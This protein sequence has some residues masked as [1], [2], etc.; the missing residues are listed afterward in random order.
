MSDNEEAGN[1]VE[2]NEFEAAY[3][4]EQILKN[5]PPTRDFCFLCHVWE[6]M[7]TA[8]KTKPVQQVKRYVAQLKER[9]HTLSPVQFIEK[10][11]EYYQLRIR[12]QLVDDIYFGPGKKR[13][14]V[15]QPEWSLKTVHEHFYDHEK[16]EWYLSNVSI[17]Q[18]DAMLRRAANTVIPAQRGAL[19]VNGVKTYIDLHNLRAKIIASRH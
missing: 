16:E 5:P 1:N 18:I 9:R 8:H 13:K 7:E 4:P 11:A 3:D 6:G 10:I 2:D 19:S 17:R 15:V 14:P 12:A